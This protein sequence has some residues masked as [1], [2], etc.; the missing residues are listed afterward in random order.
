MA[1]KQF[2]P[3]ERAVD[4]IFFFWYFILMSVLPN[5]V[6]GGSNNVVIEVMFVD[7]VCICM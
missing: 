5:H 4:F 6:I 2:V 7:V 3:A 1:G